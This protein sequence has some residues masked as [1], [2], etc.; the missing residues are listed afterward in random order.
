[1]GATD[2]NVAVGG[3]VEWFGL[4]TTVPETNPLSQL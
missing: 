1:L 2:E 4:E 3:L